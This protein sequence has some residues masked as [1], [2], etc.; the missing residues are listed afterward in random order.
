MSVAINKVGNNSLPVQPSVYLLKYSDQSAETAGRTADVVMHKEQIGTIVGIELQWWGLDTATG[1]TIINAFWSEYVDVEFLDLKAGTF[2]TK[3]FYTGDKNANF[4]N[5]S[6]G[7][8]DK[9]S[10]NI[11]SEQG[12]VD[13]EGGET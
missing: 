1:S 2:I 10:F 11:I 5:A 13:D 12:H 8:W 4:Y 6:L 9:I 7:L 3:K